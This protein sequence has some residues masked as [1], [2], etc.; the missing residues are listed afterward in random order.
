[1]KASKPW[2]RLRTGSRDGVKNSGNSTKTQPQGLHQ[3][4]IVPLGLQDLTALG[5]LNSECVL[6]SWDTRVMGSPRLACSFSKDALGLGTLLK[7]IGLRTLDDLLLTESL[8]L[9]LENLRRSFVGLKQ[10]GMS[11]PDLRLLWRNLKAGHDVLVLMTDVSNP[12]SLSTRYG[13]DGS[14]THA[15]WLLIMPRCLRLSK[16]KLASRGSSQ[17]LCGT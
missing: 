11:L 13:R 9:P 6:S 16:T 12:E 7:D 5:S 10:T 4:C 3:S 17:E 8:P 14:Q 15:W 2:K 1:M